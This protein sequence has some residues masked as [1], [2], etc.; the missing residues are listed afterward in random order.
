MREIKWE[1]EFKLSSVEDMWSRMLAEL[2]D[3][4]KKYI[5]LKVRKKNKFPN[6]MSRKL[7]VEIRKRNNRVLFNERPNFEKE[8]KYKRLRNIVIK[9]VREEKR[10]FEE[11]LANE[12]RDDPKSFYSYVRSRS[13][14]KDRVGPLL[15]DK[16]EMIDDN[17][18]MCKILNKFFSSVFTREEVGSMPVPERRTNT[19][20]LKEIDVESLCE[21]KITKEKI[22]N[23]I[24]CMKRNK[25][26]GE[27]GYNSCF[28]KEIVTEIAEPLEL[29]YKKLLEDSVIPQDWK[30]ANITAIF[31]KGS[32][33]NA[34]CCRI[35][36]LSSFYLQLGSL[37]SLRYHPQD[38]I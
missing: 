27:D 15:N 20:T 26:G 38:Y 22:V 16:G 5:P 10:N 11:K 31:K 37:G 29:L 17:Q 13:S 9:K 34:K 25:T 6:W 7:I 28:I 1:E 23:E 12:I 18:E 4:K 14:T 33:K 3:C 8:S 24:N 21:I 36:L 35:L 2:E 32:K 19:I 30:N